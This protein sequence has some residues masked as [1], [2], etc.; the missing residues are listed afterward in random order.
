VFGVQFDDSRY[1]V[2]LSCYQVKNRQTEWT[3]PRGMDAPQ[4]IQLEAWVWEPDSTSGWLDGWLDDLDF[5][6][7]VTCYMHTPV[8][9]LSEI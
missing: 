9:A 8:R 4:G 7:V 2:R 3:G 5:T 1:H 6:V